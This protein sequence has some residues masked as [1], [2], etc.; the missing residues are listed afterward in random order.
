MTVCLAKLVKTKKTSLVAVI[1]K[2]YY[3]D[4]N[5][6]PIIY[7]QEISPFAEILRQLSEVTNPKLTALKIEI[8]TCIASICEYLNSIDVINAPTYLPLLKTQ[9]LEMARRKKITKIYQQQLIQEIRKLKG[10]AMHR[11]MI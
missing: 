5:F 9:P 4:L 2:N 8:Q 10:I 1:A 3:E 6:T 7:Q 11:N